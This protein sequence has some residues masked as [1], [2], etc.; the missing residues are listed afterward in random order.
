MNDIHSRNQ[1]TSVVSG[2]KLN[3]FRAYLIPCLERVH[4]IFLE[5]LIPRI[6]CNSMVRLGDWRK[7]TNQVKLSFTSYTFA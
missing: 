3:K 2:C 6:D 7:K 4:S 5:A 1:E